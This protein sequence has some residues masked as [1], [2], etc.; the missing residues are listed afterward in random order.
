[1]RVVISSTV[2]CSATAKPTELTGAVLAER[3]HFPDLV[4]VVGRQREHLGVLEQGRSTNQRR[5]LNEK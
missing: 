4:R 3:A 2:A 5:C 1:M